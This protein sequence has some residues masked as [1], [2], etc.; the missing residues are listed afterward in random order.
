MAYQIKI[1]P[2]VLRDNAD[3]LRS[4][5]E[6]ADGV[7][8]DMSNI[9]Y[10]IDAAWEGSSGIQAKAA[11][12]NLRRHVDEVGE[13]VAAAAAKLNAIA[14]AFES[15]MSEGGAISVA[16]IQNDRFSAHLG[17][18]GIDI[19]GGLADGIRMDF[20][21]VFDCARKCSA[22]ADILG[23]LEG[24]ARSVISS[25]SGNWEGKSF[26]KFAETA[27]E[28]AAVLA[29]L[30]LATDQFAVNVRN[31]AAKLKEIDEELA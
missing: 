1:V 19:A 21:E 30:A 3:R 18:M 31:A 5:A 14:S 11:L 9:R 24:E 13:G 22:K 2:S 23:Q 7:S 27:R 28:I 15:V 12:A 29:K 16:P 8:A 26:E 17:D 4:I 20:E 25:L 6:R 10:R